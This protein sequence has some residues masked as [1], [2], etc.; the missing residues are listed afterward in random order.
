MFK[1]ILFVA[2]GGAIGSVLRYFT[3]LAVKHYFSGSFPLATFIV[4]IFGCLMIGLL[5]G[6]ALK[7]QWAANPHITLLLITGFCGGYTTFSTFALENFNLLNG[8]NPVTAI[9]YSALSIFT[10]ITC[11]WIGILLTK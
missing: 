9:A 1:S 8:G 6:W 7:Y 11:V 2:I 5:A 10:G 4:N 3:S